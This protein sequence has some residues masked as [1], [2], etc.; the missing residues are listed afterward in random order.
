MTEQNDLDEVIAAWRDQPAEPRAFSA[1]EIRR[2]VRRIETE[3]RS[4]IAALVIAVVFNVGMWVVLAA[5]A[6]N[7]LMRVGAVLTALGYGWNAALAIHRRRQLSAACMAV[8]ELPSIEYYQILRDIDRR[9]RLAGGGWPAYIGLIVPPL[10]VF[11][12]A[13]VA[14]PASWATIAAVAVVYAGLHMVLISW[15]RRNAIATYDE[16]ERFR[17][18]RGLL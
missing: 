12:G 11:A 10:I 3:A 18:S 17:K 6:D 14:E 7:R 5:L 15:G 9:L 4:A 2:A 13:A 16:M 1:L 8:S